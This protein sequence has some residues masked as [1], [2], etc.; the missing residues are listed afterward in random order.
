M[1]ECFGTEEFRFV[2]STAAYL[3]EKLW[4][5]FEAR[6]GPGSSTSTASPKAC[7]RRSIAAPTRQRAGSE[8]LDTSKNH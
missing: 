4:R 6:S 5:R 2:I 7:A 8:Q 1:I 3:D